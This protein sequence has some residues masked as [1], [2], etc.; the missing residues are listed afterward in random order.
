MSLFKMKSE[1]PGIDSLY[2][3]RNYGRLLVL[4]N[5]ENSVIVEKA[6]NSILQM[7]F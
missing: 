6:T 7:Y 1:L 5:H 2:R 3:E 4:L